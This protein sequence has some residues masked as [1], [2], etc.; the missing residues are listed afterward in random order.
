MKNTVVIPVP[1][2]GGGAYPVPTSPP[3]QYTSQKP[4]GFNYL[5]D[6]GKVNECSMKF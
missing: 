5:I 6:S 1:A 3:P 4:Q 2:P